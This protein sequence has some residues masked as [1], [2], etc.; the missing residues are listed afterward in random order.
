M[1]SVTV[2][3]LN[4]FQVSY[5][6]TPTWSIQSRLMLLW[7]STCPK[8]ILMI[9]LINNCLEKSWSHNA[10]WPTPWWCLRIFLVIVLFEVWHAV[11]QRKNASALDTLHE[12]RRSKVKS[13]L[14]VDPWNCLVYT[15]FVEPSIFANKDE[16]KVGRKEVHP[17]LIH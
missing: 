17:I 4:S 6:R 8:T 7:W 2:L 9:V 11:Q 16:K 1:L 13:G 15:T 5:I 14:R 10:Q 3:V 12:K